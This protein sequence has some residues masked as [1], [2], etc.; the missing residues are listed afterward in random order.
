MGFGAISTLTSLDEPMSPA[1]F[2][3]ILSL[4]STALTVLSIFFLFRPDANRWF[5]GERD[6]DTDMFR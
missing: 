6:V 5:K 1:G 2:A 3:L 4:V